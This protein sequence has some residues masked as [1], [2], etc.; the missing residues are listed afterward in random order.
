[1]DIC[2]SAVEA[3]S[4]LAFIK[5]SDEDVWFLIT[6]YI[7]LFSPFNAGR[8]HALSIFNSPD[9][10]VQA[11]INEIISNNAHPNLFFM[12]DFSSIIPLYI[13]AIGVRWPQPA[14]YCLHG[15]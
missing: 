13:Q 5:A 15:K 4:V 10:E 9:A 12:N 11:L 6:K 1:M 2:A 7:A 3:I 14:E 8:A